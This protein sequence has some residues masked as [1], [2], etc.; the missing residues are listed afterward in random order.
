MKKYTTKPIDY[1]GCDP[2]VAEHLK[3]GEAVLCEVWDDLPASAFEVF[4]IGHCAEK[5]Y[6][7]Q[8]TEGQYKN[9]A[10]IEKKQRAKKAS[11]II[12]WLEDR[13]WNIDCSGDFYNEDESVW[14]YSR[15]IPLCGK[16]LHSQNDDEWLPEWLE[17]Y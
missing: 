17:E 7:Y 6:P 12:K 13:N 16:K 5:H 4:I 3:R 9:A 15:M 10:P 1:D 14:F 11:E 2:V 8:T